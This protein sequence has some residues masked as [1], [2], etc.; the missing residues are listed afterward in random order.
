MQSGDKQ[1]IGSW[2]RGPALL[3]L[4]AFLIPAPAFSADALRPAAVT[5]PPSSN[6]VTVSNLR[7]SK[8]GDHIRLVLDLAKPVKI[9]Q[10]RASKPDRTIIDLKNAGLSETARQKIDEDGFPAEI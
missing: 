8:K 1:S 10:Q 2:R 6:L 3:A 9:T 5:K 4:L 7:A